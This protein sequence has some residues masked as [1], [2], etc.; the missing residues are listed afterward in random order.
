ME[1]GNNVVEISS[2]LKELVP[3]YVDRLKGNLEQ[4]AQFMAAGNLGDV[5]RF[6]HNLK[7]SGAGYGFQQLTELGAKL[8]TAA[9]GKNVPEM[10]SLI[11]EIKT[12][13]NSVTIQF[14]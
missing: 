11:A 8:E 9:V 13:I 1:M 2:D 7:G 6:G 5:Q 4:A 12:Y 10:N 3:G 14:V